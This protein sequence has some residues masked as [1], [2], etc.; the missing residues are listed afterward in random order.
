MVLLSEQVTPAYEVCPCI[1][2]VGL[3]RAALT[4]MR[5]DR[6][7]SD[8]IGAWPKR[9]TGRPLGQTMSPACGRE[10]CRMSHRN[11]SSSCRAP[12]SSASTRINTS[13]GGGARCPWRQTRHL[14]CGQTA[15]A[16]WLVAW[17]RALGSGGVRHQGTGSR[18]GPRELRAP[19][20]HPQKPLRPAKATQQRQE[21]YDRCRDGR[22]LRCCRGSRQPSRRP[23]TAP[24]RWCARSKSPEIPP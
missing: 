2:I 10:V 18:C 15:P 16:T 22:P 23:P 4:Q 21:R 14:Q 5:F 24:Q 8:P 7:G 13:R 20:R 3:G 17:A 1:A 12:S 11:G 9:L 19:T 6:V